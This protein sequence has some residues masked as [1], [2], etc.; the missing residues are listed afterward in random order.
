M[1]RVP[2]YDGPQVADR[3]LQ[4]VLQGPIDASSGTRALG[5]TIAGLGDTLDRAQRRDAEA[6]AN[7]IDTEVTAGWLEWDAAARRKYQGANAKDYETEA[8]KWW[9]DAR[10][11]YGASASP[12]ARQQ[13][14]QSLGRK[15]NQAMA[16]VS[17]HV[18]TELERHADQQAEAA[19]QTTI[20]F[21]IDQGDPAG[22]A[23]RVRQI[24]A[25]KGA[26]KGWTTEQVQAE[27]QRLL[28]TL[29][30]AY[31]TRLADTDAA[32]AR[33]YAE[34]N[35]A[36]IPAA[37]QV[38]LDQVLKGSED[39]QFADQFAARVAA[40]PLADQLAEAAEIQDPQRREKTL[41]SIR[42]N[43]ALVMEAQREREAGAADQ[44]WQLVGQGRRVPELTLLQMDGKSRVQL[45][46]YLRERAKQAASGEKVNT[47][48]ETYIDLRT[49]L[50]AGEQVDLRPYATKLA[51]PQLEQLLDT[52]TKAADPKSPKQDSML[53]DEQRI[54]AALVGLGIDRRKNPDEAGRFTAEIDRRVRAESAAR[55]GKDLTADEK[56][57]VID[58]VTM[59]KVYVDEWGR[60]PE[61]PLSLL[62]P[63]QMGKAY[64]KSGGRNVPLA[65]VPATDRQQIIQA[66]RAVG[67]QPTEQA[68]VDLYL[69][70]KNSRSSSGTVR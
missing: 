25:E 48:W 56:Q 69:R 30:L 32:K 39:N 60:D 16:S 64:V 17:G 42:Q 7:T 38:R 58:S 53:T 27:Q 55:G 31:I 45:Q 43:H 46:D 29:H 19:A 4:P 8:A 18:G 52:Q 63:D 3:P 67:R 2:T 41:Q 40:K 54:G 57:K 14:G 34:D 9:D 20:E 51:G 1:P 21:G 24:S 61:K 68:I 22:A 62:T 11:K 26:R 50:A 6:E 13:V 10:A 15:R 44:A 23:A 49:R 70:G 33:A 66:L 37:A 28:G 35:K 65:S 12:L 59:D 47:D 36:E 5:Q